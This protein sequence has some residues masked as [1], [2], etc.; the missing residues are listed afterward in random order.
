[1]TGYLFDGQ[2]DRVAI[3]D[4]LVLGAG[5]VGGE[6]GAHDLPDVL[7]GALGH[8]RGALVPPV[9]GA[10]A[11]PD[12]RVHV[13]A[14]HQVEGLGASQEVPGTEDGVV[15]HLRGESGVVD[16][17]APDG[18]VDRPE[19]VVVDDQRLEGEAEQGGQHSGGLVHEIGA[20]L[21]RQR[22]VMP[23]S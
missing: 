11:V 3:T 5:D 16:V 4:P 14:L 13:L 1:M 8:I 12:Q 18:A 7:V 9:V 23:F 22:V 20:C 17:D 15:D 2:P 19:H 6:V 10:V 21:A